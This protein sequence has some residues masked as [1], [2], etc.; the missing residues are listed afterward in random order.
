MIDSVSDDVEQTDM[1]IEESIMQQSRNEYWQ[2]ILQNVCQ[3][4]SNHDDVKTVDNKD[5]Q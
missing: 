2:Q 1:S 5:N 4:P 3:S